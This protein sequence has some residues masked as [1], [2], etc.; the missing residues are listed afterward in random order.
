MNIGVFV[1]KILPSTGGG[2]TFQDEL[3]R[4]L[5]KLAGTSRHKFTLLINGEIHPDIYKTL[6][7]NQIRYLYYQRP[8]LVD[9]LATRVSTLNLPLLSRIVPKRLSKLD[10]M[11]RELGIDLIWFVTPASVE[12]DLP[13]ITVVWDLQHRLQPWFP[14]VS[15]KGIWHA[16]ERHYLWSLQRASIIIAGTEVG[17]KEIERFYQIPSERIKI[18]P[19]PTPGYSLNAA[20]GDNRDILNKYNIPP[21]YLFYPAQFWPHKNHAN[22]LI[23]VKILKDDYKLVLPV[24]LVGS[25]KGNMDYIKSLVGELNL[26]KQIYFLGFVPQV[27]LISLYRNAF[28]LTYIT[29]FGPEN[30]PPLEAFALGCPVVASNVDG[31]EEQLGDAALLVNPKKPEQIASTIKYLYDNPDLQKVLIQRG[32]ERASKW[33]NEDFVKKVF[34]LLDELE[35]IRRC[36]EK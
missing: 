34:I 13:Y 10:R 18:I 25:D 21:G 2:Y 20:P 17:K 16:R 27:D 5:T 6:D 26:S 11:A 24:V 36:W 15:A 33:T 29:F 9:R 30:L 32:L 28:A 23:S 4:S 14:E 31:A 3:V 7:L 35:P 22:L 12:I 8:D 1:A 19:H